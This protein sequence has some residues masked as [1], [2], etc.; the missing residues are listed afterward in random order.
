MARSTQDG[1]QTK[2]HVRHDV[3]YQ[4]DLHEVA[5]IGHSLIASAE[6]VEDR[7]EEGEDKQRKQNTQQNVQHQHIA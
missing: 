7:V 6:E 2:I 5:G 4:N 1:V 3:A